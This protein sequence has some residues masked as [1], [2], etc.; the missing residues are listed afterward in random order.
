M[1]SVKMAMAP[2]TAPQAIPAIAP[3]V[4]LRCQLATDYELPMYRVGAAE[5]VWAST[6]VVDD[7]GVIVDDADADDELSV[8]AKVSDEADDVDG[9]RHD[10]SPGW[11]VKGAEYETAPVAS[12]TLKTTYA[13]LKRLTGQYT[14]DPAI[15]VAI[16]STGKPR[17]LLP[18]RTYLE[19]NGGELI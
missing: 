14:G 18:G 15:S 7:G 2:T 4:R 19:K 5:L 6:L 12:F 11:T 17:R 13:P 3:V 1:M 10:V 16:V 8:D 9:L